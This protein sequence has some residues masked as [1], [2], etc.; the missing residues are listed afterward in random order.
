MNTPLSPAGAQLAFVIVARRFAHA[1]DVIAHLRHQSALADMELVLVIESHATFGADPALLAQFPHCVVVEHGP[2][3]TVADAVAHGMRAA[4][5]PLVV[6]GEDHAY[7]DPE[8][9]A[10]AIARAGEPWTVLGPAM[11]NANPGL[12]LSWAMLLTSYTEW[13]EAAAGGPQPDL[14]GHDSCYRRDVLCAF[15]EALPQ[16]LLP[17]GGL[18]GRLRAAGAVLEFDPALRVF[19]VN[20]TRVRAALSH[21][22]DSGLVHAA[23]RARAE[24]WSIWRRVG[25]AMLLPLQWA[26][27]SWWGVR[28]WRRIRTRP[29]G[30]GDARA[31]SVRVLGWIVI[32]TGCAALGGAVGTLAGDFGRRRMLAEFELDRARWRSGRDRDTVTA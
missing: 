30:A 27:R 9:A 32:A 28:A 24:A 16:L 5:A 21:R 4:R 29:R 25:D 2:I 14:P 7:P 18:H 12:P 6:Y 20:P 26:R 11:Y 19:H 10:R 23:L 3:R 1:R 8:Y 13:V 17:G 22:L 31:R 15:G